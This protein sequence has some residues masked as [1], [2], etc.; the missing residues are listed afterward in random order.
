MTQ[1]RPFPPNTV[2]WLPTWCPKPDRKAS[3][4]RTFRDTIRIW[5]LTVGV[6]IFIQRRGRLLVPRWSSI[7]APGSGT[8]KV[9][10]VRRKSSAKFRCSARLMEMRLTLGTWI[11]SK[12]R[13][14]SMAACFLKMKKYSKSFYH[15]IH[16]HLDYS[17]SSLM[18]KLWEVDLTAWS[19]KISKKLRHSNVP[20]PTNTLLHL[21]RTQVII[22]R[23]GLKIRMWISA[24]QGNHLINKA[25]WW[26]L[27]HFSSDSTKT[28]RQRNP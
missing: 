10:R 26:A 24:K 19:L 15:F 1:T 5:R 9:K 13:D 25:A 3:Y 4:R 23:S 16:R 6:A 28:P 18:R 17:N 27:H 7:W 21:Q 2:T 8:L 11:R 20:L 22:N 12:W 14:Y